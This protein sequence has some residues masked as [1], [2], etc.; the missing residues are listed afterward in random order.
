MKKFALAVFFVLSLSMLFYDGL[1]AMGAIFLILAFFIMF[2]KFLVKPSFGSLGGIL[3]LSSSPP[4]GSTAP[5]DM[6]STYEHSLSENE[7]VESTERLSSKG[8]GPSRARSMHAMALISIPGNTKVTTLQSRFSKE[9]GLFLRVYDGRAYADPE[10]TLSSVRKFRGPSEIEISRN[11]QVSNL[12]KRFDEKYGL[13]VKIAGSDD[14]YICS[15]NLTLK[16]AQDE[17]ARKLESKRPFYSEGFKREVALAA[18]SP[19]VTLA[20]VAERFDVS[21]GSVRNWKAEYGS[22]V[23]GADDAGEVANFLSSLNSKAVKFGDGSFCVEFSIPESEKLNGVSYFIEGNAVLGCEDQVE[24]S[25][26]ESA[27]VFDGS[28]TFTSG[29]LLIPEGDNCV[30]SGSVEARLYLLQKKE[31]LEITV[32]SGSTSFNLKEAEGVDFRDV[33]FSFDSDGDLLIEGR[34]TAAANLVFAYSFDAESPSEDGSLWPGKLDD[35][36]EF[37]KY[38]F[39]T[40]KGDKIYL[41][42]AVYSKMPPNLDFEFSGILDTNDDENNESGCSGFEESDDVISKP[43]ANIIEFFI[44]SV[45]FEELNNDIPYD[46]LSDEE[47]KLHYI[48]N[49]VY[50][51]SGALAKYFEESEIE[52]QILAFQSSGV[53]KS[54]IDLSDIDGGELT[55]SELI[56]GHGNVHLVISHSEE[57]WNFAC[58][59]VSS[60]LNLAFWA[61]GQNDSGEVVRQEYEDGDYSEGYF[62]DQDDCVNE[63]HIVLMFDKVVTLLANDQ[64]RIH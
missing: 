26:F 39:G 18:L 47:D 25:Q 12:E 32:G 34:I 40:Q 52:I 15:G 36:E 48:K 33:M 50:E 19:S 55:A 4:N 10:L 11:M 42:V 58:L 23:E 27:I 24:E 8:R 2:Y 64:D 6:P 56:D 29:H 16:A 31:I 13:K 35:E 54:L 57:D 28:S 62:L 1:K 43:V 37:S 41:T 44:D 46:D 21:I 20:D 7:G 45:A 5:H 30:Y 38:V 9:F 63:A 49:S 61:I 53:P 17:D 60:M 3:R 59:K 14:S 22:D 51:V